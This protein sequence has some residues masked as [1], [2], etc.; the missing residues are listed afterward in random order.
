MATFGD[1]LKRL[2]HRQGL[3]QEVLAARLKL[4]RPTP[5]SLLEGPRKRAIPKA[6]TIKRYARAL[7][8]E[9]WELLEGVE[10]E[11]DKLRRVKLSNK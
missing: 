10:T 6:S 4:K 3:T 11:H 7:R 5:I 2:R 9:P 1:N 8:V